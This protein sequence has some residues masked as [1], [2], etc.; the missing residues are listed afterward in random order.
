MLSSSHVKPLAITTRSSYSLSIL[1]HRQFAFSL[2][3]LSKFKLILPL[4]SL[5]PKLAIVAALSLMV[6]GGL[7]SPLLLNHGCPPSCI[8][9]LCDSDLQ[10]TTTY[11]TITSIET[12]T[13]T[14]RHS[15]TA[16]G[17][18]G[19][20]ETTPPMTDISFPNTPRLSLPSVVPTPRQISNGSTPA[21]EIVTTTEFQTITKTRTQIRQPEASSSAG[22]FSNMEPGRPPTS[23]ANGPIVLPNIVTIT[24]TESGVTRTNTHTQTRSFPNAS[25]TGWNTTSTIG[26]QAA[27]P[28]RPTALAPAAV[29]DD[30]FD[31][32]YT[33]TITDRNSG[34]T[35]TYTSTGTFIP[36]FH[37]TDTD[38]PT[39]A[40]LGP[41]VTNGMGGETSCTAPSMVYQTT[42]ET[43][44]FRAVGTTYTA[45]PTRGLLAESL[46][47]FERDHMKKRSGKEDFDGDRFHTPVPSIEKIP[48][49]HEPL[50]KEDHH[51]DSSLNIQKTT[52]SLPRRL[53]RFSNPPPI[54]D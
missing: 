7:G 41:V 3:Q 35:S 16:L 14:V 5:N 32:I 15:S 34:T 2:S 22:N 25:T 12:R 17:L 45:E 9:I 51:S 47:L 20:I 27:L 52:G 8:P 4:M 23:S 13:R 44:T 50:L 11:I 49:F 48:H 18:P 24:I 36:H 1:D 31:A 42:T 21:L 6:A 28:T 53:Y 37:N 40:G 26:S 33:I 46:A 54:V 43:I 10:I 30:P 29:S 38:F 39:K 19:N